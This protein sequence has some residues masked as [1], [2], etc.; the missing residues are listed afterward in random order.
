M[1]NVINKPRY[2]DIIASI[3][4]LEEL[5]GVCSTTEYV[6]I[7]EA[8]KLEIERRTSNAKVSHSEDFTFLSE[9]L[10]ESLK[11]RVA[12]SIVQGAFGDGMEREYAWDGTVIQGAN[13][14]DDYELV[15][16]YENYACMDEDDELLMKANAEMEVHKMLKGDKND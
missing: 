3:Q 8:V 10:R 15:E 16:N 5:G 9:N 7:L 12:E 14:M 1:N 11:E 4:V 13:E 2:K 6:Q